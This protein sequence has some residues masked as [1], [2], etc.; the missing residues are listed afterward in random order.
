MLWTVT[1][2]M[3]RR[4]PI[5]QLGIF[6]SIHMQGCKVCTLEKTRVSIQNARKD[7][8]GGQHEEA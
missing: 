6:K 4:D 8:E 1:L 2:F 5:G 7:K 3:E